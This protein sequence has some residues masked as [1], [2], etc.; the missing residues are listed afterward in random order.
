MHFTPPGAS[1]LSLVERLFAEL[2]DRCVRRGRYRAVRELERALLDYLDRRNQPPTP[3]V[4]M[5]SADLIL[6]KVAR[7]SKRAS[8]SAH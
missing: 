3:F 7:L 1:W 6:G 2:T 4:W 5:A 8:N